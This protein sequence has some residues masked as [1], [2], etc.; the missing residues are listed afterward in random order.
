MTA[1]ED[2][3]YF[4]PKTGLS[5]RFKIVSI[6]GCSAMKAPSTALHRKIGHNAAKRGRLEAKNLESIKGR[7]E[8]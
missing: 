2:C 5:V 4:F 8:T 3:R 7:L 6:W 1:R